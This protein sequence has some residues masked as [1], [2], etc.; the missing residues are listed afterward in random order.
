M[1]KKESIG[2]LISCINRYTHIYLRDSLQKYQLGSG[3]FRLLTTLYKHGDGIN[4]EYFANFLKMDKATAARS[5]KKLEDVGFILRKKDEKDKRAYNVYLTEKAKELEPK[6][7]RILNSWTR[8]L[9]KDFS[10]DEQ[11]AYINFL[12]KSVKNASDYLRE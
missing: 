11:I 6:I 7:K 9:L 2:R 12:K 5:I 1:K 10:D 8:I 4:Q 3:Q